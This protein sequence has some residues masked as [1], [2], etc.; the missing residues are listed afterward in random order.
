LTL[1]SLS[2]VIFG[3]LSDLMP[4]CIASFPHTFGRLDIMTSDG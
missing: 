4:V 2:L 1:P 3:H